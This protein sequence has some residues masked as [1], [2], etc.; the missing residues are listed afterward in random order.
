MTTLTQNFYAE[1]SVNFMRYFTLLLLLFFCIIVVT[2]LSAT[3]ATHDFAV[4]SPNCVAVG[5]QPCSHTVSTS[6]S[7]PNTS[8]TP[9]SGSPSSSGTQPSVSQTISG[10]PSN[11]TTSPSPSTTP[12]STSKASVSSQSN[13]NTHS[14]NWGGK[15]H[16]SGRMGSLQQF[17]LFLWQ[18]LQ[19]I[20]QKL[21]IQLPNLTIPCGSGST[22]SPSGTPSNGG[23]P[24]TAP[25]S[26]AGGNGGGNSPSATPST[27]VSQAPAP[28]G[29]TSTTSSGFITVKGNQ[30]M[31]NGKTYKSVGF[32]FSP[33]GACW[34]SNWTTSQMDTFFSNVPKDSL[35]RFFAP[36]DNTDS[37]SFVES[38]VKEAD[39][40]SVHLI[41]VLADGDVDN[42]CDTED[43]SG[44][45]KT[46]AY[47]TNA[48]QSGSAYYNWIQQVVTPLANDPGVGMWEI[49]NEPWH[50]G[51]TFDQVGQTTAVN[52]VNTAASLIRKADGNH[53][54]VT[55]GTVDIGET[56]GVS[57]ME[58]IFKNLDVVDDHDYSGDQGG[59]TNYETS[60]F[61]QLQQVAQALGK[62]YM[63]DETGVEAGSSCS[64]S[65]VQGAWDNGS[66]GLTLQG[67]VNFLLTQKATSYLK[68]GA[69]SV[70]FWLYTGSSGGCSYENINPSDPIM[71]AVKSFVMP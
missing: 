17:F 42:N 14:M 24:S 69:S 27:A 49:V 5:N 8:G 7:G 16:F 60:E 19:L 28:T 12:C 30:L 11:N 51:A 32:N 15:K 44:G 29:S 55:L 9:N 39:K 13:G 61:P 56:G 10:T 35:A 6:P 47:Y 20:F 46:A 64:S 26:G 62:P 33:L 37:A 22:P 38:I 52:Y 66:S 57:G 25:S 3:A 40:Y 48:V 34:S 65:N 63:V 18:L 50:Q 45:G 41:I 2:P 58:A 59:P 1:S 68:A 54:L 4:P 67:R 21:G 43:S 36:P 23:A 31:L 71:A 70:G 53:H